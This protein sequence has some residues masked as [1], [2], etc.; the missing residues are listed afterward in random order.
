[1]TML[2][3]GIDFSTRSD[4]ALRRAVLLAR[5]ANFEILI[6]GVIEEG[7]STGSED[8]RQ[9][10]AST[11]LRRIQR[12]I[13]DHDGVPCR[14]EVRVGR[15]SEQ[16]AKAAQDN[17]VDLMVIGPHGRRLIRD[18]FG[19]VTAERIVQHSRTPLIAS[20]S[21]P[22]GPYRRLLLPVDLGDASRQAVKALPKL[23]FGKNAEI[24]LLHI[25]EPEARAMLGRAMVSQEMKGDYMS[26]RAALAEKELKDFA[27]SVGLKRATQL[28]TESRGSMVDDIERFAAADGTNLIVVS[29]SNKGLIGRSIL[30]SVTE[31]LLRSGKLDILVVPPS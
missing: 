4:R 2:L 25:Y 17:S 31:D 3:V 26:E 28:V 21:I 29:R 14:M 24:V 22:S 5:E 15:P 20:N 23:E 11:L 6:V 10:E 8:R 27:A 7:T 18:A 16:L 12:T 19:A 30:G 1:M 9:R 13:I